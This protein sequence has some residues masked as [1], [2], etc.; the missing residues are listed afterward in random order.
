MS[1]YSRGLTNLQLPTSDVDATP[2]VSIQINEDWLEVL[3]SLASL[4]EDPETWEDDTDTDRSEQQAFKLYSLIRGVPAINIFTD[5]IPD[6]ASGSDTSAVNIGVKFRTDIP[7]YVTGLR[8]YKDGDNTGTHT[9]YLFNAAGDVLGS[10]TFADESATGWQVGYFTTPIAIDSCTLYLA[11]Y[12]APNGHY[13]TTQH[14]FDSD[15]VNGHVRAL[16]S[17]ETEKNGVYRY[18]S[19]GEFPHESYEDTNYFV[20]VFFSLTGA[21]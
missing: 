21:I 16:K 2:L 13:A 3:L 6:S 4:L 18:G 5:Q 20:D 10:L 15:I 1:R 7:G 17:T 19:A 9:G 12:Y 8:F 14:A 11:S